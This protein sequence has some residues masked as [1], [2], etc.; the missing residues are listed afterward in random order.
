M[1][2]CLLQLGE[3][4]LTA[5]RDTGKTKQRGQLSPRGDRNSAY[6]ALLLLLAESPLSAQAQIG[7]TIPYPSPDINHSPPGRGSVF[8]WSG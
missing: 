6:G 5:P 8:I 4:G 1:Y 7:L 2:H 3:P